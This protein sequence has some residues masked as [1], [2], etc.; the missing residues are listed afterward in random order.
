MCIRDRYIINEL[1]RRH[2]RDY[3][4]SNNP[5]VET[6]TVA[7]RIVSESNKF[8]LRLAKVISPQVIQNFIAAWKEIFG[9]SAA[10]SS[11]DSTQLFRACRDIESD[12]SLAKFIKGYKG[13]EQ[14]IAGYQ[15]C[16]P[17]REAIDLFESWLN[18][19]D[20]LKFFNLIIA[21]KRCV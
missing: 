18:E 7:S 13:I 19:R 11:T 6:Q 16:Q 2:N 8:T 20:P 3:S 17:I 12:R 21:A 4:Y 15:F 9:I 1:V 14:Q 5:N 10:P